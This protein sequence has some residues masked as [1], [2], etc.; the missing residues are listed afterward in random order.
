MSSFRIRKGLSWQGKGPSGRNYKFYNDRPVEVEDKT[1]IKFFRDNAGVDGRFEETILSSNQDGPPIED[2]AGKALSYG[3]YKPPKLPA[4]AVSEDAG[5]I[6]EEP[7]KVDV[8]FT[9]STD[10]TWGC[11]FCGK[12]CKT[13]AGLKSHISKKHGDDDEELPEV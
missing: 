3:K 11:P 8:E 1:D 7:K 10:G 6:V 4:P 12:A 5:D 2:P 13:L 9:K